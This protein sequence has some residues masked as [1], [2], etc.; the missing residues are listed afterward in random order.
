[1][2]GEWNDIFD[3]SG[4]P[5]LDGNQTVQRGIFGVVEV[6]PEPST[7]VLLALSIGLVLKRRLQGRK[8]VVGAF[9]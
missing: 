2:A 3:T 5:V 6:V 8:Q 9:H 7:L 4:Y 1:V